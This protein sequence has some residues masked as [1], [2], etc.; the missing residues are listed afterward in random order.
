MY[1]IY[2]DESGTPNIKDSEN[3]VLGAIIINEDRWFEV[4]KRVK[5]LKE[6]YFSGRA[7]NVE[8][9]MCDIVHRKD[10]FSKLQSAERIEIIKDILE[11]IKKIE[12][13]TVYIVIKKQNLLK[14]INIRYWAYE[15]LFERVC[16]QLKDMND[17][18]EKI[19]YGLLLFDSISKKRNAEIWEIVSKLLKEGGWYEQN[20]HLI[21]GPIFSESH[22]RSP[23]QLSDCV[24]YMVNHHYKL[25]QNKDEN[26]KKILEEG[27]EIIEQ[28]MPCRKRY[29]RKVFP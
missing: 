10:Y 13:R 15:F 11:L 7:D 6:K 21:D 12:M 4:D 29:S 16:Y 3:F 24:A 27:F 14:N 8:I 28:K 23:L 2:V 1:L 19:E 9:H 17:G 22:I 26:M 25:N 20:R 18:K 5:E